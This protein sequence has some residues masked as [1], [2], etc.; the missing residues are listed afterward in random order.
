MIATTNNP[1]FYFPPDKGLYEV[2]PGLVSLNTDFGNKNADAKIFQID[3]Q[4]HKYHDNK[5][6]VR[7]ESVEKYICLLPDIDLSVINQFILDSLCHDYPEYFSIH[8]KT[9]R[10]NCYLTNEYVEINNGCL[11]D[12]LAMQIQEDLAVMEVTPDGDGKIIALHLCAPNHWAAQDKINKDF[13]SIHEPVPN[14]ERILQR[15]REINKACLQKGPF[16]RFAW[17][18]S[19][20][21]HLNHHPTPPANIS[22]KEW[23]GRQFNP[24]K[25][26]LFIRV[27]RQTLS[28]FHKEGLVLFTIRTYFYDVATLNKQR[29]LALINA[30]HSMNEAALN[31]KGIA[32]RKESILNWIGQ[33]SD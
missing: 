20:D 1:A 9:E 15:S 13:L 7:N 32:T 8:T 22:V 26:K 31:Y 30:I 19:T 23:S 27:E 11:F 14:I 2:K 25:P 17:G 28:G 12:N 5:L 29:R 16:V 6:K 4:F 18:L 3:N 33:I 21:Q 10:L 24:D